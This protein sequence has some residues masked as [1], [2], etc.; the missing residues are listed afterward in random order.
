MPRAIAGPRRR[1]IAPRRGVSGGARCAGRSTGHSTAGTVIGSLLAGQRRRAAR[2][3]NHCSVPGMK[4][5][6][7]WVARIERSEDPESWVPA[8]N[9]ISTGS[10]CKYRLDKTTGQLELARALPRDV[11]FPMNYGFIPHTRCCADDEETDVMIISGEPLLPLTIVRVRIIGGFV[12]S[13]SDE[14]QPEERL[15]AVA[16]DDPSVDDLHRIA[17]IGDARKHAV[18]QFVRSYKANQDVKVSFDGWFDREA[19]L[20][21]LRRAFK[22]ARKRTAK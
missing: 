8:V 1:V 19:A 21:L 6:K 7:H 20:D 13:T 17:D 4:L 2:C 11:A 18:E 22:Q 5:G 16:A 3:H 10:R 14:N 15:L 9:E 12:E